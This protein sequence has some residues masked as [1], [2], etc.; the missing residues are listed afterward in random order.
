MKTVCKINQCSGCMACV[1]VCPRKAVVVKD[2]LMY[3]NAVI[4][5]DKCINC[6][7]CHA[8]CQNN[9][10]TENGFKAGLKILSFVKDV[11]LV[12]MLQQFPRALLG[13]EER[14]VLVHFSLVDL[15]SK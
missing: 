4:Q 8:V 12:V 7:A 5:E 2:E 11:R 9:H 14:F 15:C 1:D 6:N 13:R 3:Y 10:S